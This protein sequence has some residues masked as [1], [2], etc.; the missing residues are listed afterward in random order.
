MTTSSAH[1]HGP[2]PTSGPEQTECAYRPSAAA[3]VRSNDGSWEACWDEPDGQGGEVRKFRNG[4]QSQQGA[5]EHAR[6]VET[7]TR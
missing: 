6:R 5:L 7:A 4:F 3:A 2:A 1:A